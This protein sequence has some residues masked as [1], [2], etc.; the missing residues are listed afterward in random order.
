M[1][2]Q[3]FDISINRVEKIPVPLLVVGLGGTGCDALLT[4][5]EVFAERYVLP[6]NAKGQ[7]IPVPAKTAYLAIDSRSDTPD[8]FETGEYVDISDS[9]IEAKLSDQK[10][11]LSSYERGWVN[12][13]LRHVS[14]GKGMGTVRQAARLALCDNY[15]K[16]YNAIKGA[17]NNIVSINAGTPDPMVNQ[18][19]IV[20]VTGIGGG[21][22]SGIFLDMAQILRA[23]ATKEIPTIPAKVTG[24]IVMPDVS[25]A[26]IDTASGM[27]DPIKRNSYA[28]LK[29][30]DFWMRVKQHETP[31]SMQ[32]DTGNTIDWDKAPFDHCVLI[33]KSNVAGRP[34]RN[35]YDAVRNTIA[36]NLMHYLAKE[37][38]TGNAQYSYRQYEDNLSAIDV[39]KK[40]PLNYAYR[41]IGAFTKRIPK[42]PVLYY[43]GSILFKT[44]IPLRDDSGK[45]KPDR[46]MFTDGMGKSR[47]LEITGVGKQLMQEFRT[48]TCKM[49]DFCY[50][51]LNDKIK[52]TSVQ[53]MNPAP[54]NRWH[55]KREEYIAP[56]AEK[57]AKKYLDQAWERFV[58]FAK[59]VIMDPNQGPFALEMYLDEENGLLK[60]MDEI[61]QN[62]T[63]QSKKIHTQLISDTEAACAVSWPTFRKPPMVGRKKAL[64]Q[65]DYDLKTLYTNVINDEFLAN[66]VESLKNLILRIKEYLK[67]GL[68][69]MCRTI[70]ALE[71]E[72]NTAEEIDATLVQDIYDLSTVKQSID[73]K[74]K[75]ENAE[76]KLSKA[77]L[78]EV[79]D[80]SF[81]TKRN[82]DDS[83]S[84]VEFTYR[85]AGQKAM[86]EFL[87]KKLEEVYGSVND[88]SLDAIMI[89]NVG[90]DI[91]EQQKWMSDLAKSA[92]DS[93]LPMFMQDPTFAKEEKAPYSYMS[94][95]EDAKQH[96]A[97]IATA[98]STNDPKVQPKASA[99]KDHIYTLMTWDKLPLYRYALLEDL[100]TTYD[101]YLENEKGYGMHLVRNGDPDGDYMSDWSQLPSPK[102]Y[103][104]FSDSS[105]HSEMEQYKKVKT[106]VRKAIDCLRNI[107]SF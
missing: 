23:A 101:Q 38:S 16:V 100:R 10:R 59:G 105:V 25:L 34:Y 24:Y 75:E 50:L 39:E 33:S 1:A 26:N 37:D 73:D 52:V 35:G 8:G 79:T 80:I 67:D 44:F 56:A 40:Y 62:W 61:L 49:P 86:C 71:K 87:Q 69:P 21:T 30:L 11:L 17:L 4:I 15:G 97:Y 57:A 29:E 58:S 104:L 41:A 36:E 78:A 65:Y 6:K 88:Q 102:P 2:E 82:V 76:N 64:E 72:F 54:H 90:T 22:G 5:K 95:P 7:T 51:D 81:A 60:N 18:L 107:S 14:E 66:H 9:G 53:N 91:S 77:F 103:F 28:A 93:A 19:E 3:K 46:S 55:N 20:V 84:G 63:N 45:M 27:E 96:L 47:A 99:Q 92:L 70:L 85:S 13:D 83:S 106:L 98:F 42:K 31:Y 32:Y 74:F 89:A 94:I 43:E 12:R 68:K 48:N